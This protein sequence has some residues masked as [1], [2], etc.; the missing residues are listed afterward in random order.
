MVV[1][2]HVMSMLKLYHGSNVSIEKIDL[3]IG[4]KGK[5]FGQGF[6]LTTDYAQA[7]RMA[8]IT[9]ERE[10]NGAPMI[11]TFLFDDNNLNNGSVR[12]K[13][14]DSYSIEWARFIVDNR[15]NRQNT[16]IHDFDIVYGPIADDRVGVQL[17][18]YIQNYIDVERLVE[19]L[20]FVVPT[21]QYFFGTEKSI[22][23]LQKL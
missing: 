11:N 20:K 10:G 5:D 18:R 6:Y 13:C 2:S 17:Q 19:E 15:M 23:L 21:F 9:V 22:Q 1:I 3:S 14:F 12:Y 7:K 8:E 16:P 4:R